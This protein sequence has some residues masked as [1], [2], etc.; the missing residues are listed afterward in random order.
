MQLVSD[1]ILFCA[2]SGMRLLNHQVYCKLMPAFQ[3]SGSAVQCF[4]H[5]CLLHA[6][7]ST[8]GLGLEVTKTGAI[9]RLTGQSKGG[10]LI[11]TSGHT[12]SLDDFAPRRK[13]GQTSSF[14][15]NVEGCPDLR[16]CE[17]FDLINHHELRSAGGQV[18]QLCWGSRLNVAP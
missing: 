13:N 2:C 6:R 16:L 15:V 4:F 11:D 1:C 18:V 10:S 5:K 7:S 9:A 3:P 12:I 8:A 14:Y 17:M